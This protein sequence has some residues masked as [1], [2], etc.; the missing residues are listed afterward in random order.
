MKLRNWVVK[1]LSAILYTYL[2]FVAITIESIGNKTYN[3]ILV[4]YTILAIA[5]CYLLKKYSNA[6]D[7]EEE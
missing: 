3:L 7:D 6:F 4:I 2:F 5:S 1:V